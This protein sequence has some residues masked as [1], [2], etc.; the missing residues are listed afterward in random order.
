VDCILALKSF[1]ESKKTGRQAACKYGG[2]SKP[3]ASGKYFILK[4]SDAFMNK[5]ARIHSEEATQNGFPGEQKLSPDC[6]P[7]SYEVVSAAM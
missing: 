6:S 7:E 2:I 5:N 4:N 1:S 3:L